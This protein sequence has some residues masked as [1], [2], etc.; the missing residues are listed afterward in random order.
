MTVIVDK[1][2]RKT[3]SFRE[4]KI[5]EFFKYHDSVYLKISYSNS[6]DTNA[7][8]LTDREESIFCEAEPVQLVNAKI[9]IEPYS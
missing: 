8:D 9:I 1:D 3:I 4:V 5:G 2:Q 7:F 6:M